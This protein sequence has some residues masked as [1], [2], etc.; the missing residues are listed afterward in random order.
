MGM[1][2]LPFLVVV[3]VVVFCLFVLNTHTHVAQGT[4]IFITRTRHCVH[5]SKSKDA[6]GWGHSLRTGTRTYNL[7]IPNP[8]Y[9][10]LP[11]YTT[12]LANMERTAAIVDVVLLLC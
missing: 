2:S 11:H 3:V 10:T 5:H 1:H 8:L 7:S 6:G 12:P 9:F 4:S